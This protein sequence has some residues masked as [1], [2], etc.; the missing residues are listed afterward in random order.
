MVM[1][2]AAD[3]MA[4]ADLNDKRLD[5]RLIQILSDMSERPNMS[6]PAAS[7]GHAEMTAAYRFYDNDKATWEAIIGPHV[8]ESKKRIAAEKTVLLVQDTTEIDLTRPEQQ[9]LGAGPLDGGPRRGTFVHLLEGFTPEGVPLGAAWAQSQAR[10]EESL[11]IP[12]AEK[13]E[14][15]KNAP[16]E[17][18]ESFRW[19]E[20]LRQARSVAEE[21]PN[22]KCLYVADSEADIYELFAERRGQ[23]DWL[24]R[25]SQDRATIPDKKSE[26]ADVGRLI[27]DQ[28]ANAKVLF[29][30][31][32]SVRGRKAKVT[33]ESRARRQPREDRE[34]FVEVRAITLTL[35]PPARPGQEQLPEV[36]INLVQVLEPNPPEGDTAIE[37]ILLTTLP[38]DTVEQVQQVIQYY[39]TRWMIELFFRTLKSGCRIEER[40]FERLDRLETCLAVS[41]I[42][43]WRLLYLCRMGRE[44]PDMS[45]DTIFDPS[46]WKSVWMAVHHEPP[47]A[48]APP[49]GVMM[50]LI[51]EL[52]GY[53]NR[54]NADPPGTQTLWLGLQRM[55]DLSMAW[56]IFGP[57][58]SR[59]VV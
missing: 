36:T 27:R 4:T 54:K 2:W 10:D 18:K 28:L 55:H 56:N 42:V 29:T 12:Q 34:A 25:L 26:T 13:R 22:A 1:Q 40:R 59:K 16:I 37:W 53:V 19:L 7:G 32:I 39:T 51:A 50:R 8:V 33:C 49:L 48:T 41:L 57:G 11:D 17:E 6:I 9:V 38:I 45:C 30:K 35:R 20:G 52:G 31:Q 58:A 5:K 3:E 23:L 24:I 44:F 14:I 21:C 46:E 43:A 15:R 47:P